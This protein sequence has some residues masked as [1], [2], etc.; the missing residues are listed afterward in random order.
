[1]HTGIKDDLKKVTHYYCIDKNEMKYFENQV[2]PDFQN[3][4]QVCGFTPL[5]MGE[6]EYTENHEK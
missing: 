5:L 2:K 1:M 4:L 3:E 6:Y